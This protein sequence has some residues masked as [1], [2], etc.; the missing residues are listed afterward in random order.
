VDW[1]KVIGTVAPT[2]ATALGG[3]LAGMATKA[4]TDCLGLDSNATDKDI[5]LA[6]SN[7]DVLIKIREIEKN[8]EIKMRELEVNLDS[9]AQKDRD[10]ARVR[11]SAMR[12]WTPNILAFFIV[13]GY[14]GVQCYLLQHTIP[15]EMRELIMRMLGILDMSLG[16][17]LT[18]FF[19]SS[20]AS[21][22]KDE[23]IKQLSK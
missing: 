9:I 2:L 23:T 21:R 7:P 1:K 4:I 3:P 18:Y 5:M 20:S 6:L 19:G 8:F 10:S 13:C 22:S 14:F 16:M 15:S 12:D 11:Q 17:V